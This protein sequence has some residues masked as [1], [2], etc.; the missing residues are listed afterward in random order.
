MAAHTI[1]HPKLYSTF[2]VYY[3][4]HDRKILL[5]SLCRLP[6][7]VSNSAT[8]FFRSLHLI[9]EERKKQI[10]LVLLIKVMT[11]VNFFTCEMFTHLY[12][13]KNNHNC[14]ELFAMMRRRK[15]KNWTPEF[16]VNEKKNLHMRVCLRECGK[17]VR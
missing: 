4:N 8:F 11:K 7:S 12:R 5:V 9:R 14:N 10:P 6:G 1:H 16:V 15:K 3:F 13:K 17:S 2:A